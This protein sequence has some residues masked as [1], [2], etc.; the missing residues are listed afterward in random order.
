M[1]YL[2]VISIVLSIG[3]LLIFIIRL[4][5]FSS[6]KHDLVKIVYIWIGDG[7]YIEIESCNCKRNAK[8][9]DISEFS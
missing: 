4:I 8:Q 2:E 6:Y 7:L 3:P 9:T 1:N 5:V